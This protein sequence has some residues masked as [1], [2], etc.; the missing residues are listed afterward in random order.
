MW[1]TSD[2]NLSSLVSL[3]PVPSDGVIVSA[4]RMG[5]IMLLAWLT[6]S[7][8]H[9]LIRTFRE[10]LTTKM[11][12]RESVQRAETV[13]RMARHAVTIVVGLLALL[14]I[15]SEMGIS[16]APLLGAAGVA[17]VAIGFGAQNL[18]KD[19]FA[20][21][22][23][24]MEN[25]IR[26]GDVITLD[27]HTGTV[28]EV[29]LRYVRLRDYDG[30]V[31]FVPNGSINSVVSMSRGHA[32]AVVNVNVS[33]SADIDE[34]MQVMADVAEQMMRD[35]TYRERLDGVY[36]LAGVDQLTGWAV[37]LQIRLRVKP[38]QQWA[39]RRAYLRLVKQAFDQR[40]IAIPVQ[41]LT[42]V[43]ETTCAS[44]DKGVNTVTHVHPFFK[45]SRSQR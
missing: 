17:G 36:E 23:L 3:T 6:I 39:I 41:H 43:S 44:H 37:V 38:L 18:V 11:R 35:D 45:D 4:M 29:T 16:V 24:L 31:H 22:S 1:N 12:D 8:S 13:G 26:Q 40:H 34:A 25:Q 27:Q 32:F 15:L 14:L 20:G 10:R 19:L 42:L 7:L 9:K 5:L 21:L 33:Y 2:L 28:E 30:N